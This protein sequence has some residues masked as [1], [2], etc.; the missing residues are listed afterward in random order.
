[1]NQ[2]NQRERKA[3]I[4]CT[5]GPASDS[6]ETL[7]AMINSGMDVARINFSHGSHEYYSEVINRI[8]RVAAR[9]GKPVAILQDLQGPRLRI[10]TL[11][12]GHPVELI[13][14]DQL[15]IT[16]KPIEGTR[17][18]ISTNY[19]KLPQDVKPDDRL[20]LDDG[21]LE[22]K[23][24]QVEDT[25][26]STLVIVGGKLHSYKGI[27]LPG[28]L[29]S[30]PAFTD[31]D[32][33]DL[34]FG[35]SHDLDYVAVSFVQTAEDIERVRNAMRAL[36]PRQDAKRGPW[37][38][39]DTPII[40]KLERPSALDNLDEILERCQ[41]VMVARGDLGVELSPQKVP[42]AQKKILE[43][44]NEFGKI[45]ITAT[46]MLDSMVDN[47]SPTRAEASDVANAIFDG[48]DAVMLSAETAIGTYPVQ[49]V[50]VMDEVIC[51]AEQHE[52]KW[53]RS[54]EL[55]ALLASPVTAV[56]LARAARELAKI[57]RVTAI[58]AFT[59]SGRSV[60][61]IY[62]T[63]PPVP[64]MAFTVY[65]HTCARMALMRGVNPFLL[66]R[67]MSLQEMVISAENV[68]LER[69]EIEIGQQVVV[70]AGLPIERMPPSNM[71]LLHTVGSDI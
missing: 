35:L 25:E 70:I 49:V 32:Q 12:D 56:A 43:R 33:K 10:G 60:R 28:G 69:S 14:G 66:P 62:K 47:P 64:I 7:T 37:W 67:A 53:G 17:E 18:R 58:I 46:Q 15:V 30:I 6:E 11:T 26:I 41:G 51:E 31:K 29:I 65:S 38:R 71:V 2:L 54:K 19:T 20:L 9:S 40:A 50:Q 34:E 16:T 57:L 23:V 5:I 68:L 21:R 63:R 45:A 13:E 24:T 27:N 59:R 8:R 52:S 36:Y 4:I 42:S 61:L 3:K 39:V 22:L 44:A 55:D 48:T 1:M